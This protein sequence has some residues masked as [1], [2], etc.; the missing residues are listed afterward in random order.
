MKTMRMVPLG[1]V[2][3]FA[4]GLLAGPAW[5]HEHAHG[6]LEADL[7]GQ[8]VHAARRGGQ[9]HARLGQAEARVLGC[10][11]EVARQSDFKSA[12]HGN[13]IYGGDNRFGKIPAG[14]QAREPFWCRHT[15]PTLG[16]ITQVVAGT[17]AAAF[18][19]N[20]GNPHIVVAGKVIEHLAE[21]GV[22]RWV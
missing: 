7:S 22:R 21:F 19:G 17:E 14:R 6:V 3:L 15:F 20:D 9:P 5:A 11:D 18:T 12:P 2:A 1:L 16:L 10:D 4:I 13:T 8:A